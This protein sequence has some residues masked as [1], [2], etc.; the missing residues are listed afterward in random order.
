MEYMVEKD[1]MLAP[2]PLTA[3]Q[4][5]LATKEPDA[6]CPATTK[7]APAPKD[8]GAHQEDR[9]SLALT[10]KRTLAKIRV[11]RAQQA[12]PAKALA[13]PMLPVA[14]PSKCW[15]DKGKGRMVMEVMIDV[16]AEDEREEEEVEDKRVEVE[17]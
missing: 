7:P 10:K 1:A 15:E 9:P 5:A 11:S 13:S 17:W 6:K 4:P 2:I 12:Q 8:S 16:E 14:G 3:T